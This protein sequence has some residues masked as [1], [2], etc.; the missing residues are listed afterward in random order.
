MPACF[1]C[2]RLLRRAARLEAR[3]GPV[4]LV[5]VQ[6]EDKR[7]RD[8]APLQEQQH[9]L[10]EAIETSRYVYQLIDL[11]YGKGDLRRCPYV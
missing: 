3:G 6:V 5:Y 4:A 10:R 1:F 11:E 9:H 2:A 7:P 8:R